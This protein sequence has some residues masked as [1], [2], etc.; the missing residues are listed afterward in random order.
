MGTLKTLR[1]E[2]ERI[3]VLSKIIALMFNNFASL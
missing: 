2:H 1:Q 3:N